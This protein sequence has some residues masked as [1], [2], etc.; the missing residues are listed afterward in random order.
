MDLVPREQQISKFQNVARANRER[1][2]KKA[3]YKIKQK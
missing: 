1:P 3:T 2:S